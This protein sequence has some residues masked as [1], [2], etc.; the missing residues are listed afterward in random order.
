[1]FTQAGERVSQQVTRGSLLEAKF[2]AP[3]A[4]ES[5]LLWEEQRGEVSEGLKLLQQMGL[6][7]P[8]AGAGQVGAVGGVELV[9]SNRKKHV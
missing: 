6:P 2:R 9:K 1:M 4:A 8:K 7:T 3:V 5:L